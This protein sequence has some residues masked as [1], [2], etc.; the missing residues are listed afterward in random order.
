MFEPGACAPRRRTLLAGAAASV[1]CATFGLRAAH[2]QAPAF[3][4]GK[5]IRIVAAQAPGSSNDATARALADH[6]THKLGVPV[7]VE[8]KPGGVSMIAADF[9][10][11]APAD[12]HTLLIAL[13]SQLAQAPVLLKKPSIDPDKDLVPIASVGV[14]PVT[15]VVHKDFPVQTLEQL[16]AYARKKPVNAGNYAIGSGWQLM[17]AQLAKETGAQFNVVNYKGTGAMLMDLYAGQVDI[18]AGSLAGIGAGIQ[19][20]TVRPIVVFSPR[21]SS[22]MPEVPTWTDAGLRGPAFEDLIESNVLYAPAQT[23]AAVV[24][25][26][27]ALVQDAYQHSP[28]MKGALELLA[29]EEAPL[30]G[31]ELKRFI[32]RSWPSYRKLTREQG[33]TVG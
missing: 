20:G 19:K 3:A 28:R 18:G 21:R 33:M 12:G 31:P 17:L 26:I 8:N 14:G 29:E 25:Q 7:V 5:P 10:A 27:A 2:A 9:V 16:I 1:A 11:R 4:S 32:D 30:V 6:F 22:R 23:P 24:E 15:G 13:N